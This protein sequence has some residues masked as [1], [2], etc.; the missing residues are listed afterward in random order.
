MNIIVSGQHLKLTDALREY[1]IMKCKKVEKYLDN[2]TE[3]K[4]TLSVDN[5][6]SQGAI[7][8]VNATLFA[9]GKTINV[10]SEDISLY[11]AIDK[12]IDILS[13]QARKYKEM[14]KEK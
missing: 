11:S 5:T 12:M 9:S 13:R 8:R 10:E 7:H 14:M 3:L 6:K 4:L 1:S 2:I